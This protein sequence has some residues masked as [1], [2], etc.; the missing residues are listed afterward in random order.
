MTRTR[1]RRKVEAARLSGP[2]MLSLTALVL[3]ACV[4]SG[5][6][7]RSNLCPWSVDGLLLEVGEDTGERVDCGTFNNGQ[8][9]ELVAAFECFI[10]AGSPSEFTVRYGMALIPSTY[11][12]TTT[13]I[14]LRIRMEADPSGD[15]MR[16][17][18]VSRCA[19][20]IQLAS[21]NGPLCTD[22]ELL[23]VCQDDLP[24]RDAGHSA[25]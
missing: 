11:I 5:A 23:Y 13:G 17:A 16:E 20:L 7:A 22:D 25:P 9:E 3:G 21:A 2:A 14:L 15:S 1:A 12:N 10:T 4:D 8:S 19:E 6:E 18:S 24:D